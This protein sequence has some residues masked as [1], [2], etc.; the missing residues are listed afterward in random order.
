MG[1]P[2]APGRG[3]ALITFGTCGFSSR[4]SRGTNI[5][6]ESKTGWNVLE[7]RGIMGIIVELYVDS[8]GVLWGPKKEGSPTRF[9]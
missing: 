4:E 9:K 1:F 6:S 2:S 7:N 8:M 5:G 3:S